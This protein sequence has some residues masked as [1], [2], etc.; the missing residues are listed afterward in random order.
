[1]PSDAQRVEVPERRRRAPPG[2][3]GVAVIQVHCSSTTAS[4]VSPLPVEVVGAHPHALAELGETKR[5]APPRAARVR[6]GASRRSTVTTAIAHSAV[7]PASRAS[8]PRSCAA[9]RAS[10][11]G[12]ASR[13]A[14][15]VDRELPGRHHAR[16]ARHG[17]CPPARRTARPSRTSSCPRSTGWVRAEER[18]GDDRPRR[19]RPL[20][21]ARRCY[22]D[23]V[24]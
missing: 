18:A 8:P 15:V 17:S 7:P 12:L 13:V 11:A 3:S 6:A 10:S 2:P 23:C 20:R 22:C 16:R 9:W 14:A 21:A 5:R 1:M 24:I 4:C 19:E